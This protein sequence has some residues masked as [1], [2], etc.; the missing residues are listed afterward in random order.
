MKD[1]IKKIK[2]TQ[3]VTFYCSSQFDSFL[4]GPS[5]SSS[6]SPSRLVTDDFPAV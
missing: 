6:S 3:Q 1:A 4:S 5:S 2:K